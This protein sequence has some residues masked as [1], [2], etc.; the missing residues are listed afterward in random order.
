MALSCTDCLFQVVFDMD[1]TLTQAHIDFADMRARTGAPGQA[2]CLLR[3]VLPD[4]TITDT[5]PQ[6]AATTCLNGPS[7]YMAGQC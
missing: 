6:N 7:T 2:H 4:M 5:T 1:G 3:K